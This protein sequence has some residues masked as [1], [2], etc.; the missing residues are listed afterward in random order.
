LQRSQRFQKER[1]KQGNDKEMADVLDLIEAPGTIILFLSASSVL[2][3]VG[4]VLRSVWERA[5]DR[6]DR[7]EERRTAQT[8]QRLSLYWELSLLALRH[9]NLC[10]VLSEIALSDSSTSSLAEVV[11]NPNQICVSPS[12][13]STFAMKRAQSIKRL[14]SE[15]KDDAADDIIGQ[16][17]DNLM[18]LQSLYKNR[19]SC[20]QPSS[21]VIHYLARIDR[22]VHFII[23]TLPFNKTKTVSFRFDEEI[24]YLLG[25]EIQNCMTSLSLS[26]G[27][28]MES[29][30]RDC[31]ED[32]E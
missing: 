4:Y 2:T 25:K 20:C 19:L 29:R 6:K 15:V 32:I 17:I 22:Q 18:C 23:S 5:R 13:S 27:I 31:V 16:V 26:P 7:L 30:W 9:N 3:I 11:T 14:S 28:N 24:I 12:T 8:E 10:R 21:E 1:E